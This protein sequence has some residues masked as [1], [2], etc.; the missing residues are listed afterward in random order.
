MTVNVFFRYLLKGLL[1]VVPVAA[2]VYI[3][4][5][6]IQ[7]VDRLLPIAI[8][9]IGLVVVI[10]SITLIGVAADTIVAKPFTAFI[11]RVIKKVPVVSFI[12]SSLNDVVG[13][14]AGDKKKFNQPVLVPFDENANLMKPGFVTQQDFEDAVLTEYVAVYMPHSYNFSGNMFLV[15]REKLVRLEG[16][17]SEMMKY[18]V[19]AGLTGKLAKSKS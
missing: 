6:T 2:T 12:Y 8:P 10:A 15:K 19:S 3:I 16:S 14:V 1:L 11:N 17:N 5:V 18:I 4:F 7:W 9:G 13:A